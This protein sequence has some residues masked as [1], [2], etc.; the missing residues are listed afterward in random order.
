MIYEGTIDK[1]RIMF[2]ESYLKIT[3]KRFSPTDI[4]SQRKNNKK[5][6]GKFFLVEHGIFDQIFVPYT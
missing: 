1:G 4:L 2:V 6:K 3:L 5:E